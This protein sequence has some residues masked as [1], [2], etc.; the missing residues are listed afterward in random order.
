MAEIIDIQQYVEDKDELIMKKQYEEFISLLKY[1]VRVQETK[2]D[3]VYV[4]GH[5]TDS[6][7]FRDEHGER[8]TPNFELLEMGDIREIEDV[9]ISTLMAFSPEQVIVCTDVFMDTTKETL[10]LIWGDRIKFE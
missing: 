1:L 5:D 2:R 8:L 7:I 9:I 4:E 3:V 10:K 6:L